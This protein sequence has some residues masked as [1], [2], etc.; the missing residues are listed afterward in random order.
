MSKFSSLGIVG[1]IQQWIQAFITRRTMSVAMDG[2][3]TEP[4]I[5]LSGVPQGSV[6]GPFLFLICT[7]DIPNDYLPMI[8]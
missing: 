1:P 6:L 3:E 7:N 8:V 4:A 5:V 2:E